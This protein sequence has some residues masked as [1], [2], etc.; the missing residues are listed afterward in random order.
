M[1][2][3]KALYEDGALRFL[4]PP[5]AI[6]QS[7]VIVVFLDTPPEDGVTPATFSVHEVV[8]PYRATRPA[9]RLAETHEATRR[10]QSRQVEQRTVARE[11]A[12]YSAMHSDLV[13]N[14]LGQYVAIHNGELVDH[15]LE[16]S[17]LHQR[18]RQRFGRQTV[19][20]QR[21]ELGLERE[22]VFRSPRFDVGQ[23]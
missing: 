13:K 4:E 15:D 1:I 10:S 20:V 9:R 8:A 18:I 16:F 2:A 5:P 22:L 23:R 11:F 3:V 19:L 21:V 12:A 17:D 6:E 7:P 14:Y